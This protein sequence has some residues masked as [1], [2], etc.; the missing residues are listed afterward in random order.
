MK[1]F[2]YI[3]IILLTAILQS[4]AVSPSDSVN[5]LFRQGHS[6]LLL[7]MGDNR[8]NL[9]SIVNKINTLTSG[10]AYNLRSIRFIGSASPEGSVSINNRLSVKRASTVFDYLHKHT[11]FNDS[12]TS[13]EYTGRDWK[14]LAEMVNNDQNVPDR[15]EV[16]EILSDIITSVDNG[17]Q[18]P[19]ALINRLKTIGGGEAY[20]YMYKNLY[21]SLR[22]SKIT[23]D[24]IPS[25]VPMTGIVVNPTL[26]DID[27]DETIPAISFTGK[28]QHKPFYMAIKTNLLYDAIALPSLSAEF[29]LGKNWSAGVNWTYGWWD[30]DNS[31]HYW[32]AY[33]G[34]IVVRKW[35]GEK[36]RIKPLTGHHLGVFAGIV[37]YDFEFGGTGY[38]GGLPG[39]TLW[40]R[41][42]RY[43]GIE[44]GYSLPVGRRL[45]IDFSL[46]LGYLGGKVIKYEPSNDRYIWEETKN[47]SWF[48]PVKAEISLTWLIGR[49]NVNERR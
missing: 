16:I 8:N 21:P 41:C 36:S 30:K 3:A 34:D 47:F 49:G 24:Y 6:N 35:L 14:G 22:F 11:S 33:G 44:Y 29:Y 48:G 37:T 45:N 10:S 15:D 20:H 38:M 31:H 18:Q 23:L 28:Q 43:A 27:F 17:N 19:E 40:D 5:I 12:I 9:D 32:R 7:N 13:F 1:R 39:H 4:N 2:V 26:I 25:I 42:N 46:G